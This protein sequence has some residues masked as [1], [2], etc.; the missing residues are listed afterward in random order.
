M[1]KSRLN[2]LDCRDDHLRSVIQSCVYVIN[3]RN[4][5]M[6]WSKG[7]RILLTPNKSSALIVKN[8]IFSFLNLPLDHRLGQ[9][10][11]CLRTTVEDRET[12]S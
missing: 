10:A 3:E 6:K 4:I 1:D 8:L 7:E 12:T 9:S 11:C 2:S 5:E